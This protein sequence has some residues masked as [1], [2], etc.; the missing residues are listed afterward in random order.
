MKHYVVCR[1]AAL[2]FQKH[3][4]YKFKYNKMSHEYINNKCDPG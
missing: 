3:L 4:K 2:D 1:V